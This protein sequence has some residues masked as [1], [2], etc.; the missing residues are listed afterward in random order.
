MDIVSQGSQNGSCKTADMNLRNVPE[1]RFFCNFVE[2]N[3]MDSSCMLWNKFQDH[4]LGFILT[5]HF[6]VTASPVICRVAGILL[7]TARQHGSYN[8]H[9]NRRFSDTLEWVRSITTHEPPQATTT[10]KFIYKK[11]HEPKIEI[12]KNCN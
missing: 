1:F 2:R 5:N 12:Y 7:L 3:L 11:Y 4:Q 6:L 8:S 9:V 10:Q